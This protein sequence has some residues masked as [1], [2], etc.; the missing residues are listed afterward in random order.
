M[1][2]PLCDFCFCNPFVARKPKAA[3]W[4]KDICGFRSHVCKACYAQRVKTH[5]HSR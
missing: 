5:E 4:V 1:K 2:A 3:H